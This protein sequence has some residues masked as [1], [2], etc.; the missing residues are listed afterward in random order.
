MG[1]PLGSSGKEHKSKKAKRSAEK[2]ADLEKMDKAEAK[3]KEI[4][5]RKPPS[6]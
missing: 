3:V 4:R 2:K 6:Q 1:P 5:K